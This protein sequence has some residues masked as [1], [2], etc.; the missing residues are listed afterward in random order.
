MAGDSARELMDA[1]LSALHKADK[2][3]DSEG[4]WGSLRTWS[5]IFQRVLFSDKDVSE[6]RDQLHGLRD[7][8][9]DLGSQVESLVSQGSRTSADLEQLSRQVQKITNV[10]SFASHQT[11]TS[12]PEPPEGTKRSVPSTSKRESSVKERD[13][14]TVLAQQISD[15]TGCRAGH[16]KLFVAR[17][18][19]V[20]V[21]E[22]AKKKYY[23]K[24]TYEASK[25]LILDYMA[26]QDGDKKSDAMFRGRAGT[27]RVNR[28]DGGKDE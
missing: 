15:E 22:K 21:T 24:E 3:D 8:V 4:F 28:S 11:K 6:L 13:Q 19:L 23:D 9:H 10:V 2:E 7:Q 12:L 16:F 1:A 25:E 18:W 27:P 5:D 14:E 17:G 20:V 26:D